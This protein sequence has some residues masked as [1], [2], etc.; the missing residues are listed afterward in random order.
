MNT[1]TAADRSATKAARASTAR[2]HRAPKHDDRRRQGDHL[3]G[4]DARSAARGT[5]A[6]RTKGPVSGLPREIGALTC[7]R[8]RAAAVLDLLRRS[9]QELL[10]GPNEPPAAGH[11]ICSGVFLGPCPAVVTRHP[12]WLWSC[13]ARGRLPAVGLIRAGRR[14]AMVIER[15]RELGD[16]VFDDLPAESVGIFDQGGNGPVLGEVGGAEGVDA[17]LDGASGLRQGHAAARTRS[18]PPAVIC[19]PG[20]F[21][22]SPGEP[23]VGAFDGVG[24]CDGA[25]RGGLRRGSGSVAPSPRRLR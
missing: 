6:S 22:P 23:T 12:G 5:L 14:G 7:G 10:P 13:P 9:L 25:G 18:G 11:G 24:D 1:T 21:G 20:T 8:E 3:P 4:G 17:P 2:A 15:K 16:A 19:S